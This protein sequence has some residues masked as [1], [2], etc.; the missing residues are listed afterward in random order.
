MDADAS[1][2]R[3]VGPLR[4]DTV[5]GAAVVARTAAEVL[6]RAAVHLSAGSIEEMRWGMGEVA[7]RVLDAQPSMAPLVRLLQDV[8]QAVEAADSV[9]GA[10]LA[11]ASAAEAFRS[12]LDE[13]AAA[14]AE[15][16]AQVLPAE[17]TVATLSSSS[18][19]R[20][21]L[22]AGG[23]SRRVVCFESRP[24]EEGRSLAE[25]LAEHG[26]SVTFA[27]DAAIYSLVPQCDVVLFGADSLGD[28]GVVN[29]IGSAA[30]AHAADAAGVPVYVLCDGTKILPPG[31]PQIVED[32]RPA[33]EVWKAPAGVTVWNRY[34][35][36]VPLGL[37]TGV[38]TES[39]VLSPQEVE[40]RRA[41]M[42]F[43]DFLSRW[44]E[45]R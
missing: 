13:R 32:D 30:L 35:E 20:G 18:T 34:F 41:D 33:A 3:L 5:S 40:R 21:A 42:G 9:E 16:A 14:V 24:L 31:F 10:R 1:I 25:S 43:P 38:V 6:R 45:G 22:L 4:A 28:R 2:D 12:G 7:M 15:G 39:A 11:A 8:L 36:V 29:K 17:G 19:V 37:V 23:V 44:A 27:V 26:V